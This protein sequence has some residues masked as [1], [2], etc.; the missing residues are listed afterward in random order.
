MN[1]KSNVLLHYSI[2]TLLITLVVTF[3]TGIY[4]GYKS[5][6][7]LIETHLDLY[8]NLVQHFTESDASIVSYF[9]NPAEYALPEDLDDHLQLLFK[10]ETVFRV[11]LWNRNNTV[12]WSDREE[13]IGRTFPEEDIFEQAAGGKLIYELTE[14]HADEHQFEEDVELFL[15]IYIPV[16]H[17]GEVIG[18]VEIYENDKELTEKIRELVRVNYIIIGASGALLYLL[19]FS[20]FAAAYRR[21]KH[22]VEQM[23]K[24]ER[25]T[26]YA[27]A[28]QA[29]LRDEE[30]GEHLKRTTEYVRIIARELARDQQYS[31]YM[32]GTYLEDLVRSAPLHDIGK[33]GIEDSILRKPGKLTEEEFERIKEHCELGARI[34][35]Q[36]LEDISFRSFLDIAI[37]LVRFH[38]ERWDGGGYP[39]G[40][41]R[42]EIPISARIMALADV[43]DALRS[44]RAYKPAFSHEKS[45]EIIKR[46]RAKQFDPK[47][48]DAFLLWESG[49]K[50]I[51]ESLAD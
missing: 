28:Y 19:L 22:A 49:F 30:T 9:N 16:L 47:V 33:V 50:H 38:H 11:K 44:E 41:K 27:L 25:V 13:L 3:S 32:K 48:V 12:I 36:A 45:V 14:P 43:Y 39:Q 6:Q 24:T 21:Q 17:R 35:E 2:V 20:I 31:K 29:G 46:E 23:K 34:L 40:L 18:I 5:K 26:I 37:H 4:M 15:E 1:F 8:P 10:I 42:E 7:H 51:S